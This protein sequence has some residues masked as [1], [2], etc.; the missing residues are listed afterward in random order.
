MNSGYWLDCNS[1]TARPACSGVVYAYA[2][3]FPDNP[4]YEGEAVT[5][6]FTTKLAAVSLAAV[7]TV[8]VSASGFAAEAP[9]PASP[10]STLLASGRTY[11]Q[12]LATT[13]LPQR[14]APAMQQGTG[15]YDE[16]RGFFTTKRGVALV[17]LAAAGIGYMWYSKSHDRIHSTARARL[18]N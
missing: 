4:E 9:P 6:T 3:R 8:A 11:V 1:L 2:Q 5:H 14:P 13:T 16:P 18:D 7:F 12:Q 17:V 10:S 15:G